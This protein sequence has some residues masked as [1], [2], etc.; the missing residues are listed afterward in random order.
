MPTR[1]EEGLTGR[2]VSYEYIRAG[3]S[4]SQHKYIFFH[5]ISDIRIPL[6][7]P[8][9]ICSLPTRKTKCRLCNSPMRLALS[10]HAGR[11]RHKEHYPS[12]CSNPPEP[13]YPKTRHFDLASRKSLNSSPFIQC[14]DIMFQLRTSYQER[15]PSIHEVCKRF[16]KDSTV[17]ANNSSRPAHVQENFSPLPPPPKRLFTILNIFQHPR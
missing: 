8:F 17:S 13:G 15:A 2:V 11:K 4:T 10:R 16:T 9:L 12:Y 7:K 5:V 14:V 3:S 6:V 1:G